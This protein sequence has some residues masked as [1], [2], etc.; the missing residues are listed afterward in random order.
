MRRYRACAELLSAYREA[1]TMLVSCD[2]PGDCNC[3]RP[4]LPGHAS[5]HIQ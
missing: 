5:D 4:K 1:L 2:G 3:V